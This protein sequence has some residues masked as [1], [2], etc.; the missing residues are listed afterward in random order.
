MVERRVEAGVEL[1]ELHVDAKLE[2][3]GLGAE[4]AWDSLEGQRRVGAAAQGMCEGVVRLG[5]AI[6]EAAR[7]GWRVASVEGLVGILFHGAA[8]GV[9]LDTSVG[10]AGRNVR[11]N[12]EL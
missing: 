7:S 8:P 10:C 5:R 9:A 6:D 2:Q 12:R 1:V 3:Y 4:L 11:R